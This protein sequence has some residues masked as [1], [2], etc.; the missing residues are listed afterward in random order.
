MKA[1]DDGI[2]A[3]IGERAKEPPLWREVHL[4]FYDW[5]ICRVERRLQGNRLEM[6]YMHSFFVRCQRTIKFTCYA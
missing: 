5:A 6:P 1:M 4:K 2:L 3:I